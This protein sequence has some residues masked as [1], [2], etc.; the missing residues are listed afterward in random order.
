MN[1]SARI[2]FLP[3][4]G[5][6]FM[7]PV[8]ERAEQGGD[9]AEY[10]PQAD[11]ARLRGEELERL[12]VQVQALEEDL[13]GLPVLGVAEGGL[14]VDRRAGGGGG[15]EDVWAAGQPAAPE[16]DLVLAGAP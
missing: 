11:L 5:R 9:H 16:P 2:V 3:A 13:L 6:T 14:D 4:S 8:V 7:L 1:P 15:V 12:V 10:H